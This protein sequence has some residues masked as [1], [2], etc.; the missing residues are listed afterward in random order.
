VQWAAD[1]GPYLSVSGDSMVARG[2]MLGPKFDPRAS[3]RRDQWH[4]RGE[5]DVPG[6]LCQWP[7]AKREVVQVAARPRGG[8]ESGPRRG[9]EWVSHGKRG[10]DAAFLIIFLFFSI[11]HF[12]LNF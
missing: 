9:R 6:P 5:A 7:K 1:T 12:Y 4:A 2:V 8:W 10:L 11:F 3:D